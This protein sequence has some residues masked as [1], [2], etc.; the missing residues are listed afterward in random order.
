MLA[1][2][3]SGAGGWD[4]KGPRGVDQFDAW[5]RICE[6]GRGGSVG[7]EGFLMR[8]GE[9]AALD[10]CRRVDIVSALGAQRPGLG[11]N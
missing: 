9:T 8:R 7:E 11:C 5:P 1:S 4:G 3:V 6:S 10:I 2:D